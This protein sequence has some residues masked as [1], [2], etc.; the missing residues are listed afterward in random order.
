MKGIIFNLLEQFCLDHLG[1][2]TYDRL[3]DDLAEMG[4]DPRL[5]VGPGTYADEDFHRLVAV[6]AARLG[7]EGDD[8]LRRF[9]RFA[10]RRLAERYPD[11]FRPF[12]HPRDFFRFVGMVHHVEVKK[13]YQDAEVPR[14]GCSEKEDG[15]LVLSYQSERRLC[16]FV[17]GLIAGVG[18]HYGMA[19]DCSHDQCMARGGAVCEFRL[20]FPPTAASAVS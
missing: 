18:E 13:L 4:T 8:L 7:W 10:L 5:M 19:I 14:F 12:R 3:V 20:R 15:S 17:E 2:E 6:V 11:F 9:G 16:P 1:E